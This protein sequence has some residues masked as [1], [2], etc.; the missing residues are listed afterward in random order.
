MLWPDSTSRT[1]SCLNSSVYRA[2]VA[3]V[4]SVSLLYLITQQGIR[5]ARARSLA[6]F[7][8]E[9]FGCD[10]EILSGLLN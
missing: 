1:A 7:L 4:I 9:S 6:C 10:V 5:F 3:F 2:R 8:Q